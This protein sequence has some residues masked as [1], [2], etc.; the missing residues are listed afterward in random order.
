[1]FKTTRKRTPLLLLPD[2]LA[3]AG[4]VRPGWLAEVEIRAARMPQ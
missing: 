4:L 3:L 2:I 1:M